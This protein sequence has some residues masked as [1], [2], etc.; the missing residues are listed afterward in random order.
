MFLKIFFYFDENFNRLFFRLSPWGSH[1]TCFFVL[2][3]RQRFVCATLKFWIGI[4]QNCACSLNT[5]WIFIYYCYANL[6]GPSITLFIRKKGRICY[7]IENI[8]FF[9]SDDLVVFIVYFVGGGKGA[10]KIVCV[11]VNEATPWYHWQSRNCL[12]FMIALVHHGLL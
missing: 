8:L 2:F 5:K 11:C 3:V 10:W 1:E 6:I 12:L 9:Y 4:S 7:C